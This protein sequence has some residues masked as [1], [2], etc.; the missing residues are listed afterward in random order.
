VSSVKENLMQIIP[1][2]EIET[3][4]NDT[5]KVKILLTEAISCLDTIK[6]FLQ[7]D[8]SYTSVLQGYLDKIKNHIDFNKRSHQQKLDKFLVKQDILMNNKE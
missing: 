8:E 6:L 2:I 1:D 3:D 7:Q 4:S 5:S